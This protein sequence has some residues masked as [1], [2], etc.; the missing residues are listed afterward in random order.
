MQNAKCERQ[1]AK[2]SVSAPPERTVL[3]GASS[4]ADDV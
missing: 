1:I 2:T 4:G 3:S